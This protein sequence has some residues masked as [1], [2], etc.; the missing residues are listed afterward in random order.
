MLLNNFSSQLFLFSKGVS[1]RRN[2]RYL[3]GD[4][5]RGQLSPEYP[6]YDKVVVH[7]ELY[8]INKKRADIVIQLYKNQ[9]PD[10]AIII[11]AKN[12]KIKSSSKS[13]IKQI[14]GYLNPKEFPELTDFELYGCALTKNDL[15][16]HNPKITSVSWSSI[17]EILSNK[18]GLAKDYLEFISRIKG[19]M[20]FYEKEVFSIPAGDSYKFQ[21]N[22]PFIYECPNEGTRYT[23]MKK[24][25]FMAFRKRLGIMEKIFGVE[26][27]IIMNPN[28]DFSSFLNN[29]KYS[30]ELKKRMTDYCNEYWGE[31]KYDDS[32]KQFFILSQSNQ[33]DLIHKPRPKR[34]NAFRA[35]YKLSELLDLKKKTVNTNKN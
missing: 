1:I 25:L 20:K 34:N 31:G 29:K 12:A 4:L 9:N 35:Y 33:I 17:F 16:M 13:I 32:E 28:T 2:D 3:K 18:T 21:Y 19:T 22:Y 11:E 14:S 23:S 30:N 7:S 8:S 27:I 5:Q 6:N 10:L 24:P 26:E 15:V